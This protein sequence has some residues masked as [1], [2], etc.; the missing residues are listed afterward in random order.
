MMAPAV[1]V[2][3]LNE[4]AAIMELVKLTLSAEES[5]KLNIA[6]VEGPFPVIC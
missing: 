2:V 5:L 4:L 3:R 6:P 1:V